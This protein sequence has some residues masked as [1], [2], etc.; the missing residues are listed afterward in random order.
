VQHWESTFEGV[1]DSLSDSDDASSRRVGPR[2]NSYVELHSP[3]CHPA[4]PPEEDRSTGPPEG[5][6]LDLGEGPDLDRLRGDRERLRP[7]RARH[8]RE[9]D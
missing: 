5:V 3:R 2:S 8:A 4:V 9:A 6:M 1:T 7:Y